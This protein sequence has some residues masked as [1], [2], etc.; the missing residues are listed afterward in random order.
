[1][2]LQKEKEKIKMRKLVYDYFRD[3]IKVGTVET[4]AE[5]SACKKAGYT[6]KERLEEMALAPLFDGAIR[7]RNKIWKNGGKLK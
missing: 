7:R 1:M 6:V 2:N 3:G 5:A 4:L